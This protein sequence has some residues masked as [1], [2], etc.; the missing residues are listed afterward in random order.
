MEETL[1]IDHLGWLNIH[2]LALPKFYVQVENEWLMPRLD[3]NFRRREIFFQSH[4][5]KEKYYNII[6]AQKVQSEGAKVFKNIYI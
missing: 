2:V 4:F 5:K 3:C 6:C 1:K